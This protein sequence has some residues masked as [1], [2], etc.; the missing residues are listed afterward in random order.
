MA[1]GIGLKLSKCFYGWVPTGG[2]MASTASD[3]GQEIIAGRP[4]I[5]LKSRLFARKLAAAPAVV[6]ST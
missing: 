5:W 4:P 1:K 2:D 6:N 3:S